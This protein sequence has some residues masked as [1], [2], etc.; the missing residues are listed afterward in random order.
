MKDEGSLLP[1]AFCLLPSFETLADYGALSARAASLLL[2]AVREDPRLVLGLPTGRTP[3]GMYERIV[4]ECS[5]EYRC[6][7]D[8]KTFN[9]D[10][11]AGIAPSHPGSYHTYIHQQF[12]DRVDI[13]PANAHIPNGMASDLDVECA[14]Y[15]MAIREAGGLGLTFLGL[16][17]NGHIGFN[18]PG[19]SFDSIT[20]VVELSQSTRVANAPLFPDGRVPT[21]AITMGIGTILASKRVVLLASGGKKRAAIERLRSGVVEEVFPASALWR[22]GD[23]KVLIA[24]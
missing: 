21:H 12:I 22:H 2:D 5:R 17:T 18:E 10:E 13:D 20:R 16:G 3:R 7:R 24:D 9:L 19:T 4:A 15:E 11:Y 6:F 23:V 14:R 1:S 8:A